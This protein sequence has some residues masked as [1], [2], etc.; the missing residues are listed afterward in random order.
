MCRREVQYIPKGTSEEA[1]EL[2]GLDG[3]IASGVP[4]W[5][6]FA[7]CVMYGQEERKARRSKRS[8]RKGG[9]Q[10]K[11]EENDPHRHQ[12]KGMRKTLT[13]LS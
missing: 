8:V 6:E 2:E 13:S 12:Q 10:E 1:E 9:V 4:D 7:T 11:D 3:C 5:A